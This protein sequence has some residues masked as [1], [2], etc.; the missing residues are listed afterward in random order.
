MGSPEAA[1]DKVEPE[2]D[3]TFEELIAA[4]KKRTKGPKK[5]VLPR[6]VVPETSKEILIGTP[7]GIIIKD[8]L[9]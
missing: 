1:D 3:F 4:Q 9:T 5:V 2:D 8:I 7:S 6:V